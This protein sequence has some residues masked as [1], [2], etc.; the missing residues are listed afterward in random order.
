MFVYSNGRRRWLTRGNALLFISSFFQRSSALIKLDIGLVLQPQDFF[1]W[2]EAEK[3]SRRN[4][5]PYEDIK[6][7]KIAHEITLIMQKLNFLKGLQKFMFASRPIKRAFVIAYI[8]CERS[9][10]KFVAFLLRE[11]EGEREK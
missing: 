7:F 9:I 5:N 11:R 8:L 10:R 1:A 2:K 6:L 4:Q 3:G